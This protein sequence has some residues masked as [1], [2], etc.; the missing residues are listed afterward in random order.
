MDFKNRIPVAL[1]VRDYEATQVKW[2]GTEDQIVN[3]LGLIYLEKGKYSFQA[4]LRYPSRNKL[5]F[6]AKN[7]KTLKEVKQEIDESMEKMSEHLGMNLVHDWKIAIPYKARDHEGFMAVIKA[8]DK[9]D[10]CRV[11]VEDEE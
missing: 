7:Y 6:G 8:S 11:D 9:F 1:F 3:V 2:E 4:R 5:A 10:Y